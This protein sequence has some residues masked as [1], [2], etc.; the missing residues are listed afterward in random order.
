MLAHQPLDDR[1][2]MLLADW[3]ARQRQD[4]EDCP[5]I[6]SYVLATVVGRGV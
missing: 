2:K 5:L 3:I 6:T 4:G 1:E